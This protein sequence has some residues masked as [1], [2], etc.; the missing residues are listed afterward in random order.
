MV[1]RLT[2]ITFRLTASGIRALRATIPRLA[3]LPSLR[4]VTL[5]QDESQMKIEVDIILHILHTLRSLESFIIDFG[6]VEP[7]FDIHGAWSV[8]KNDEL[9]VDALLKK[10][11][12]ASS[13][14]PTSSNPGFHTLI[15]PHKW[16]GNSWNT[17][18]LKS[19]FHV[20]QAAPSLRTI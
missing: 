13:P 14:S 7:S 19:L 17:A 9:Q 16:A 5:Q 20:A 4:K 10:I 1:H 8:S 15:L 11:L 18:S 12:A 6:M 2:S 3:D